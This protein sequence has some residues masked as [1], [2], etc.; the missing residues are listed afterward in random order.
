M[1][2]AF[3]LFTGKKRR[4]IDGWTRTLELLPPQYTLLYF[5]PTLARPRAGVDDGGGGEWDDG[6]IL[7]AV[8][9]S[10]S[11]TATTLHWASIA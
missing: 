10:R 7:Q 1:S 5:N 8:K 4:E 2:R 11:S 6:P 9:V 3:P